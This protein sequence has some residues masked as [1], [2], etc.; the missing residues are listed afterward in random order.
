MKIKAKIW[1]LLGETEYLENMSVFNPR[2][3]SFLRR[4]LLC[5]WLK[6]KNDGTWME[7]QWAPG[8]S[9]G[10]QVQV[11]RRCFKKL[12]KKQCMPSIQ[13]CTFELDPSSLFPR[14]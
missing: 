14:K 5:S 1:R 12:N 8:H 6:H 3:L 9:T 4:K 10:F 7:E 11:C 2:F 13:P